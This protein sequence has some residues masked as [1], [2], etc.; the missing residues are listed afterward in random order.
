[1]HTAVPVGSN[2]G[3]RRVR[4]VAVE[5]TNRSKPSSVYKHGQ[6]RWVVSLRQVKAQVWARRALFCKYVTLMFQSSFYTV[7]DNEALLIKLKFVPL[8]CLWLAF[9]LHFF[10][11][12]KIATGGDRSGVPRHGLQ[13]CSSVLYSSDSI[14]RTSAR[15]W[16]LPPCMGHNRNFPYRSDSMEM[17]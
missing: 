2:T 10:V 12:H 17:S 6:G 15:A 3:Q 8:F 14:C 7:N 4:Q 11:K 13:H 1:M 5:P 16:W 9:V